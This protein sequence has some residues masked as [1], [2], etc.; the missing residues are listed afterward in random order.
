M[1]GDIIIA[2]D[3]QPITT[4][5]EAL[6][7]IDASGTGATI[8]LTVLRDPQRTQEAMEIALTIG[9]R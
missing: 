7:Q 1:R 4:R 6:E 5:D 3:D 2:I 8:I 9:V